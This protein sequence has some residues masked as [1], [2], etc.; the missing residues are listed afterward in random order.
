MSLE[1]V[2]IEQPPEWKWIGKIMIMD[3][4]NPPELDH[5]ATCFCVECLPWPKEEVGD[6]EQRR[7]ESGGV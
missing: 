1:I 5:D 2:V 3:D 4:T 6:H 7:T